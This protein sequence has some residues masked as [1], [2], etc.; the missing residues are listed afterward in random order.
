[1]IIGILSGF[2]SVIGII[3]IVY[4]Y[5]G[6]PLTLWLI[7]PKKSRGNGRLLKLNELP[8]LQVI[9]SCYNESNII[10]NRIEN[11]LSQSYSPEKLSILV[12]SDGSTDN[13]E[14]IV[15]TISTRNKSVKLFSSGKNY[16]KNEALNLAH[17]SGEFTGEILC[18][19]DAD[20]VFDPGTLANAANYFCDPQVGLVGGNIKYWLNFGSAH[21]AEGFFWRVENMLREAEGNLGVLI[22]CTGLLIM[23]RRDLFQT[24]RS[25]VNT[26]FAMPLMVLARGH[27][28]RFA[29]NAIVRSIFPTMQQD[30][31]KRRRRTIIRALTTI[32]YYKFHVNWHIRQILFWHKTVRFNVMPIQMLI[33][34]SNVFSVFTCSSSFWSKLLLLQMIF[35]GMA[36][37]GWASREFNLRLPFVHLP[38]QFTLQNVVAFSAVIAF[39]R[40]KR[41]AK[42]TPPR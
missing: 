30:I 28:T 4:T 25:E 39:L 2:I 6:F 15:R 37:V 36:I 22:S 1:M 27:A 41:V 3:I 20:S 24:L 42:W 32:A 35:Y 8:E 19:T 13:S 17:L 10:A 9:I 33:L 21:Q 29:K 12:V 11:I 26:D 14:D 7:G 38:Y 23:M 18:F 31:L 5:L 40:G 34:I 16:G